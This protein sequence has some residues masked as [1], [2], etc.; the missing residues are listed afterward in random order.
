MPITGY[1]RHNCDFCNMPDIREGTVH[2]CVEC[3]YDVCPACRAQRGECVAG[4]RLR[5]MSV[6]RSAQCGVFAGDGSDA[7]A[8]SPGWPVFRALARRAAMPARALGAT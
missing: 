4:H 2:R 3:D 1:D 6:G 8:L 5:E 7:A